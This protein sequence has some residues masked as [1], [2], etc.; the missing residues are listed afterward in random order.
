[1]S[2]DAIGLV[3]KESD[4]DLALGLQQRKDQKAGKKPEEAEPNR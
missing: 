3:D 4:A 2:D 1:M